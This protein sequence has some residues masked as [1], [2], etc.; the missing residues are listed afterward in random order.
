MSADFWSITVIISSTKKQHNLLQNNLGQ[1]LTIFHN[2]RVIL[3][4]F[5]TPKAGLT[6]T[7]YHRN[8]LLL[9]PEQ[10]HILLGK[11]VIQQSDR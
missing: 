8:H 7:P 6:M 4:R 3:G 9:Q 10:E 2:H 1:K 5:E 11:E